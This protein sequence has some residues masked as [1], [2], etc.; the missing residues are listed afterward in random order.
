MTDTL[1]TL[2]FL[3][4]TVPAQK[5]IPVTASAN[6]MASLVHLL[7]FQTWFTEESP[8]KLEEALRLSTVSICADVISQDFA[9]TPLYLKQW[10]SSAASERVQGHWLADFFD[11]EP[12]EDHTWYELKLMI[13]LHLVFVQNAFLVKKMRPNGQVDEIIPVLP[14]RVRILVDE[15]I[16]EYVYEVWHD[17]PHERAMMDDIDL[18]DDRRTYFRKDQIIHLRARMIDG[19]Y[20]Y[21]NLVAG[22]SSMGLFKSITDYQTRL[23]KNDASLRGVFQKKDE[24]PLSED[25]FKRLR[26]QLAEAM[27][28]LREEAKPIVLEQGMEFS[29]ISMNAD[30]AEAVKARDQAVV[31]VCRLF[32]IPPHKAMHLINVKYENM[33][34]LE[35]SYL[36]DTMVPYFV[37]VEER[38]KRDLLVSRADRARYF[39]WFD[40]E[41]I[42]LHDPE[43]QAKVIEAMRKNAAM[44]VDEARQRRGMN[45]IGGSI[46]NSLLVPSSF[47][48]I[49]QTGDVLVQAAGQTNDSGTAEETQ[50]DDE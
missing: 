20:G 40:R 22:A 32:R 1:A 27:R 18:D 45:P 24:S 4:S 39:P 44:T 38:L 7:G 48:M 31:D 8:L 29:S 28:K 47:T 9:K 23:Y 16:N 49:S 11:T 13:M 17:T 14:G 30:Q 6:Q 12:N 26:S 25:S 50:D 35:K 36:S 34:T 15:K 33:E 42:E 41:A 2:N 21:S 10:I 37:N 43:K 19:L 3:R 5:A 46:G